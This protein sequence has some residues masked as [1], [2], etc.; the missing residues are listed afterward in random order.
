MKS[1][2]LLS[3]A[4]LTALLSAGCSDPKEP[5]EKNFAEA[6]NRELAEDLECI[7]AKVPD[8]VRL[9]KD[10][11]PAET[12][13]HALLEALAS[14]GLVVAHRE[15][16][17]DFWDRQPLPHLVYELTEKGKAAQPADKK[18][19]PVFGNYFCYGR[20]RV[21]EITNFTPPANILSQVQYEYKVDELAEWA[22]TPALAEVEG[23]IADAVAGKLSA[24]RTT[25]LLTEKGWQSQAEYSRGMRAQRN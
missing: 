24:G 25:L 14:A 16:I 7:R 15:D 21:V 23:K 17:A 10:G 18:P 6:I 12:G 11:K 2:R 20:G 19:S 4:V 5:N 9:D 13:G 22:K 3:T 8:K 1:R